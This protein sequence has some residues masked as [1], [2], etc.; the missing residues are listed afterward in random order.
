MTRA[1]FQLQSNALIFVCVCLFFIFV[2][3]C[4]FVLFGKHKL[5]F[6]FFVVVVSRR[7][8]RNMI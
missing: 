1:Q 7:L 8:M 6:L 3:V 4:L 5:L 2:F